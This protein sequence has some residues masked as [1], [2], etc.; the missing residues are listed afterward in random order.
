MTHGNGTSPTRP[1]Q[2]LKELFS[3]G[4]ALQRDT[5]W[6]PGFIACEAAGEKLCALQSGERVLDVATGTGDLAF[7]EQVA[8][9]RKAMSWRR[10]LRGVLESP[11]GGRAGPSTSRRA[12]LWTSVPGFVV[13][14]S[15]IASAAQRC[16]PRPG[17]ARVPARSAAGRPVDVLDFSTPNSKALKGVHDL[18]YFR[19]MRLGL[20]VAWHR[21]ATIT[22]P[23]RSAPGVAGGADKAMLEA[24]FVDPATSR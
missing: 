3:A 22:P 5:M 17:A 6:T 13:R 1:K 7:A 4:K 14:R 15:H 12:M 24:G 2:L 11:G 20:A 8:V 21:D 16:R 9:G 10:L 18:L 23:I 19:L